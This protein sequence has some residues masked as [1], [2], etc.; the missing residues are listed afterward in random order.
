MVLKVSA[1]CDRLIY[2]FLALPLLICTKT[3]Y[4]DFLNIIIYSCF[5][6]YNNLLKIRKN[7]IHIVCR[8]CIFL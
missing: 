8:C 6:F 7:R 1:F 3:L 2:S 4:C 5:L